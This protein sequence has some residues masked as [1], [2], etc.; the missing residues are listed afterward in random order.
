MLLLLMLAGAGGAADARKSASLKEVSL[1]SEFSLRPGQEVRLK[2]QKLQL[3]F[4]SVP[5]DSRCPEGTQC[6]W[7]GNGKVALRLSEAGGRRPSSVMLNTTTEPQ[8]IAHKGFTIKLVRLTPHPK[9]DTTIRPSA[10]VATLIITRGS[11][12]GSSGPAS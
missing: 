5:E 9:A 6:I 1:G 4:V 3:K 12:G 2:G 10:Y 7:A 8:A 11:P